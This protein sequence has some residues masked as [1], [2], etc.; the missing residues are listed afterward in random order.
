[1][2]EDPGHLGSTR[3]FETTQG[4]LTYPELSER[5]AVALARILDRI[6]RTSAQDIVITPDWL[7]ERHRDLAGD[8][9]PDWAGR[10]RTTDVKVGTLE[11]PPYYQV[12]MLVRSFCDDLAERLRHLPEDDLTHIASLLAWVD[13][14]FQW[15]HPF[16]DFNGRIGRLTLAALL[17]KLALPPVE[18]APTDPDGRRAY[19][20]A[21]RAGDAG[22]L[23]PLQQQWIDRL[24]AAI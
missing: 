9:F 21:L 14:R 18:T 13:W 17:Y 24:A 10:F 3:S 19:L 16:K 23:L 7:C 20:D 4:A 12:P 8:L 2:V 1:M 6:L 5:L 22:D 11:P 15:I